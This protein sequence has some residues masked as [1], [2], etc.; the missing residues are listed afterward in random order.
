[1]FGDFLVLVGDTGF[2]RPGR[3]KRNVMLSLHHIQLEYDTEL[4][5]WIMGVGLASDDRYSSLWST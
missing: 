1:M 3:E 5:H 2:R 4:T